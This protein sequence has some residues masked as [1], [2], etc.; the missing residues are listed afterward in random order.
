MRAYFRRISRRVKHPSSHRRVPRLLC[1]LAA[2]IAAV[3]TACGGSPALPEPDRGAPAGEFSGSLAWAE[4]EGLAKAPRPL[5][6]QGAEAPRSHIT[7]R[8]ATLGIAGE[9][10]T[11]TAESKGFGPL[12]LTHLVATLPGAST[13]RLV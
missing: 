10:L 4:L 3:F 8:L 13:D 7:A 9:T 5:G 11:T 12:P 1:A 6:P 2:A